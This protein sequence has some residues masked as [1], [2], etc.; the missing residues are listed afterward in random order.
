MKKLTCFALFILSLGASHF[1]SAQPCS[2]AFTY[3]VGSNKTVSFFTTDSSGLSHT[4]IFGDGTYT[5]TT[6]TTINHTYAQAGTFTVVHAVTKTSTGCIDSLAKTITIPGDSC[7]ITAAFQ[8]RKDSLNCKK[9]NFANYS[10][11]ISPNVH[12]SWTFGDG[13]G[14]T[15][16]SPAHIYAQ[17]GTYLVSL[18]SEAGAGCRRQV[19]DTVYVKCA[20]SCGIVSVGYQYQ[21]DTLDCKTIHFVNTSSSTASGTHYTWSFGDG[22]SATTTTPTHSYA[23]PGKYYVCLVAEAGTGCRKQKCDSIVVGCTDSCAYQPYFSWRADSLTIGKIYFTNLTQ[24]SATGVHYTWNFGDSSAQSHDVS[25]AHTYAHA[26]AY[27]VC[28][29]AELG[30]CRKQYCT[31]VQVSSGIPCNVKAAFSQHKLDWV[32]LTMRFEAMA[33]GDSARYY[34]FF[35]DSTTASGRLVNHQFPKTGWYSIC[36]SVIKGNC[37]ASTCQSVFVNDSTL[38]R[39]G[40]VTSIPNPAISSVTINVTLDRPETVIIRIMDGNGVVRMEFAK[41]GTTGNNRFTLPVESLSRGIYLMEIHTG[42]RRWFSRF[43]KG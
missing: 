32:P 14:S 31:T 18:V 10:S 36:L 33:Q 43:Q 2:A 41:T 42:T 35:S 24:S 39:P 7:T 17:E 25:P 40:I 28:L 1:A 30:N 8:Y 6:A 27:T 5:T 16:I 29:V 19:W 34:W 4:W 21:K 13:T 38:N 23:Q 22:T 20:D 26:G 15:D 11:P 9:I 12:F 37:S 3:T